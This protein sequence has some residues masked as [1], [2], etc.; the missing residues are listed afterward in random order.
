MI[1]K[2]NSVILTGS[3]RKARFVIS[4]EI[5]EI[6]NIRITNFKHYDQNIVG[7][8]YVFSNMQ[9]IDSFVFSPGVTLPISLVSDICLAD[10]ALCST[11]MLI[12]DFKF[13]ETPDSFD[14]VVEFNS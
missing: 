3:N 14:V 9:I 13:I 4:P 1:S 12:F 2:K 7:K 8:C 6:S 10:D 5:H 11:F